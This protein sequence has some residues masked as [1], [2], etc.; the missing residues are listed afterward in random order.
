[1][2]NLAHRQQKIQEKRKQ[3]PWR[4]FVMEVCSWM[5]VMFYKINNQISRFPETGREGKLIGIKEY[6]MHSITDTVYSGDFFRSFE[7]LFLDNE[8]MIVQQRFENENCD[9]AECYSSKNCYLCFSVGQ[10]AENILYSTNS[11]SNIRNIVNSAFVITNSDNIFSS[12]VVTGSYNVFYGLNI[13]N[14]HNI[15]F[16]SNLL[17]CSEC[18]SCHDLENKSY[19]IEN[20]EYTPEEYRLK[21][22]VILFDKKLFEEKKSKIFEKQIKNIL[23]SDATGG[24]M[25]NCHDIQNGYLAKGVNHGRN[26]YIG[27]G[28]QGGE[29]FYDAF[30]AGNQKDEHL[31]ATHY[32]GETSSHIYCVSGGANC[33]NCYYGYHLESCSFCLGCIGLKNKSYCI[34][35]K[36]YT[37]EERYEKVDEIFAQMEKDGT[38]GQFFPATMNPFYFND[39]AAYLI[40]PSFTKEEVT[41]KGYLRRD[42][43]IKVDIPAGVQTVKTSEL[44][45]FEGRRAEQRYID[46]E[47]M[48]KVILDEQGNIYRIVKM[49][50]DFLMKYGLPLPRKHRLERMKE[51][52][53]IG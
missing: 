30:D 45:Q 1:M 40:D 41:A 8:K 7:N 2:S 49:E 33:T 10:G 19:C 25:I 5:P 42:E 21:K 52:F 31:Y 48:K 6:E 34:L 12:K 14:S 23:C 50:Y 29:Y 53:R 46:P 16:S 13:H 3:T 24:G 28:E 11:H 9:Y 15:W 43:P 20:I 44:D 22:A 17:G 35:N 36:Q 47:I 18:I 37:K 32:V 26:M 39:T 4:E 51:N 27:G 38:L